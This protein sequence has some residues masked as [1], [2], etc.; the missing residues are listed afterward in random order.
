MLMLKPLLRLSAFVSIALNKVSLLVLV[1]QL[2]L[3]SLVLH[4]VPVVLVLAVP[5]Q[6]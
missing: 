5:R 1:S 2:A 4:Q 3:S 6:A